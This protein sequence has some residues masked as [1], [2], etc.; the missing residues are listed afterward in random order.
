LNDGRRCVKRW[1]CRLC[2]STALQVASQNG[3]TETA[4]ALVA[5]GADVHCKI[6]NGCGLRPAFVL[7]WRETSFWLAVEG[8]VALNGGQGSVRLG[9][10]ALQIDGAASGVGEWPH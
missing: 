5:A 6:L 4:K 8:R 9:V 1:V 7:Q 10:P 3:Y 2:R